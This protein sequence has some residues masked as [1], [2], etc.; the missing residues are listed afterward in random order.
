[1]QSAQIAHLT[2]QQ[3][4]THLDVPD[5]VFSFWWIDLT[6]R[7]LLLLLIGWGWAVNIW[8]R[9]AWL[10]AYGPVAIA[11]HLGVAGIPVLIALLFAFKLIAERPIEV[12]FLILLRYLQQPKISVWRSVRAE[13]N[14]HAQL[15]REY[16][17]RSGVFGSGT[18]DLDFD[19]ES[20]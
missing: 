13:H 9:L 16:S 11:L 5:K 2:R 17:P 7:Q 10:A 20:E 18:R 12:W 19:E 15:V 6:V 3:I 4:P 14:Q 1:M 8:I